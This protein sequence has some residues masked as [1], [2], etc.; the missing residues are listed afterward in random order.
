M[1]CFS[2]FGVSIQL[3]DPSMSADICVTTIIRYFLLPE[4]AGQVTK[5]GK[6][7]NSGSIVYPDIQT[8]P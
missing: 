8:V 5:V 3:L 2:F 6:F 1:D 7:C 4:R